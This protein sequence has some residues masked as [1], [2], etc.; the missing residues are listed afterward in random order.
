MKTLALVSK[1][2][3]PEAVRLAVQLRER[4]PSLKFLAEKALA[5]DLQWPVANDAELAAADLMVTLGGDGTLI[6]AAR[7]LKG[8]PVPILGINLG[9]L[10][11]MTEVPR[12]EALA[13]LDMA[14]AG[15]AKTT[16]RMK[17]QCR[18]YRDDQVLLEDEV[19]N[20][21]VINKG[22]LARIA[23]FETWM[24]GDF[25][26][27]FKADGIICST[28]TGSTAYTLS[29]GGP[30]VY[31]SIDCVILTPICPHALT[32]KPIVVPGDQTIR[33]LLKERVED[34]WVTIDG[35]VGQPLM[36]GDRIEVERSPNRVHLVKNP[37]LDYFGILRQK[38]RWGERG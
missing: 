2:G 27:T 28:P 6:H 24:D 29:A 26:A 17:L 4:Y 25:V 35:Q 1:V 34:V 31:P 5:D 14:L 18:V 37:N 21:L 20:D 13:L 23:D 12:S 8:R 9:S 19:L 22:A 32:Q 36:S 10:G 11:F 15:K 38:L 3:S 30:I 16:S 33:I 7:I